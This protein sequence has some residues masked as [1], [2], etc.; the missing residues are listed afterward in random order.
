[1]AILQILIFLVIATILPVWAEGSNG[2]GANSAPTGNI[3][4]KEQQKNQCYRASGSNP[5]G[6]SE[7]IAAPD[8]RFLYYGK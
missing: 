6:T 8:L 1:M 2:Y 7:A 3:L 5:V 4:I